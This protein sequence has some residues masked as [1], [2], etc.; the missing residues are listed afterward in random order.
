MAD[1]AI[2]IDPYSGFTDVQPLFL[3]H[4]SPHCMAVEGKMHGR[5][6]VVMNIYAPHQRGRRG[7]LLSRFNQ[8]G[9]AG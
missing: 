1:T 3:E 5:R 4:W 8:A 6:L 7:G 9:L 2:L